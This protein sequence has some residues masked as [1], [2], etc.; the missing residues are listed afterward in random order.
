MNNVLKL[1]DYFFKFTSDCK[2][3]PVT[4][5]RVQSGICLQVL[6][7]PC[8]SLIVYIIIQ[9]L[10]HMICNCPMK[11]HENLLSGL[12]GFARTREVDRR[13]DRKIHIRR[14]TSDINRWDIDIYCIRRHI[15]KNVHYIQTWYIRFMADVICIPGQERLNIQTLNTC[16]WLS[17][18]ALF[19]PVRLSSCI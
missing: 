14:Q 12:M 2:K 17:S 11:L 9:S 10:V 13:T 15:K 4:S 18:M 8:S 16:I 1:N 7:F 19:Y 6:I 5:W 3:N